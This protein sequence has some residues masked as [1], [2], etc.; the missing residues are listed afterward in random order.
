M[1]KSKKST[2]A[3][4]DNRFALE[5]TSTVDLIRITKKS[6]KEVT[7][8]REKGGAWKVNNKYFAR[9]EAIKLLLYTFKM[10]DVKFPAPESARQNIFRI[11]SSAG[12]KVEVFQNGERTRIW[13]MGNETADLTGTYSLLADAESGENY[14]VPYIIHIPGFQGILN[15]RFFTNEADWRDRT[16]VAVSPYDIASINFKATEY[17]D[18]SFSIQVNDLKSYDLKVVDSKGKTFTQFDSLAVK[19]YL[20]YFLN[21]TCEKYFEDSLTVSEDS[22]KRVG[23]AF[24]NLTLKTKSGKE[25]VMNFFHKAPDKGKEEEFGVKFSFDPNYV[26]IKSNNNKDFSIGQAL[27]YGK[28]LQT[29]RYFASKFVKK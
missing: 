14:E 2:L 8:S 9:K 21:L 24:V 4:E 25:Y 29:P 23:R 27:Q 19:Q 12:E 6:G 15:T 7:L 10:V 3:G 16:I 5:D 13:L 1:K 18:S 20:A 11:M 26:Y 22:V 28:V 17:P